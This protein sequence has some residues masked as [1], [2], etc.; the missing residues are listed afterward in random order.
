MADA[1]GLTDST[2]VYLNIL[3]AND[4][5]PVFDAASTVGV[6]ENKE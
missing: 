6:T 5:A 1:A 2:N 4:N 3:D